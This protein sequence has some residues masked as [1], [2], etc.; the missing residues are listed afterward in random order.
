MTATFGPAIGPTIGGWLTDQ[1]GWPYMFFVNLI[2]GA[3]MLGM[4]DLTLEKSPL[5]LELAERGRLVGIGFMMVGLAC[6]QTMLD[7]GNK[8]DWFGSPLIV[9]LSIVSAI[10]LIDLRH[11]RAPKVEKPA[12][13]LS[14]LK[15]RNFALGTF[16]NVIVGCALFGSVQ[17]TSDLSRRGGGLRG[18][19]QIGAGTGLGGPPAA[20]H[21]PLSRAPGCRC[22]SMS[23]RPGLASASPSSPPVAS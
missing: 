2:P 20:L 3:V 18:A 15:R 4:L 6:L 23:R 9:K 22:T 16:A 17:R 21:H 1:F 5:Q 11:H 14:L 10:C 19:Q 7:E 8:D 13:K 12:I